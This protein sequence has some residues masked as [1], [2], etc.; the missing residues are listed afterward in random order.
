MS[1]PFPSFT[2]LATTAGNAPV[3]GATTPAQTQSAPGALSQG[4]VSNPTPPIAVPAA[5]QPQTPPANALIRR[6]ETSGVLSQG[7][8]FTDDM[9]VLEYIAA[10]GSQAAEQQPPAPP[11]QAAPETPA[12]SPGDLSAAAVTFQQAG[13][14][15][16][17]NGVYVATSPLAADVARALNDN[18]ARQRAV[19][20]ELVDP[21]AF[22][23]TYGQDVIREATEPLHNEIQALRE[24][25]A[26]V[27][28]QAIPDPATTFV[29]DNRQAL[30]APDGSYT[31]AGA[32]YQAAWDA[33]VRG[34][35]QDR[36]AAHTIASLA[37]RPLMSSTPQAA[38]APNNA[39]PNT[40]WL[41]TITT[42]AANPAFASPGSI[43]ASGPQPGSVPVNNGGFP[44]FTLMAQQ[45][46]SVPGTP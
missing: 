15:N 26:A 18:L 40:P 34:G 2:D 28:R 3:G 10:N 6:L 4:A 36:T 21:T 19:Q 22:V 25:L 24:Q 43:V 42:Q 1:T 39:P 29:R 12:P 20:A 5:P 41:G 37:A 23:R 11:Q 46:R 16:F 13:M 7:H 8:G 35:V 44:D 9:Q 33:A 14:L 30:V 27:A 31:A 17:Q 32:A 38:P 45:A